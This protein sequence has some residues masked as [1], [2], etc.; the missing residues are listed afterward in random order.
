MANTLADWEVIFREELQRVDAVERQK[1]GALLSVIPNHIE[2]DNFLVTVKSEWQTWCSDLGR[3]PN[4]LVVLYAGLAFYE[5]DENRLWPQFGRAVGSESLQGNRNQQH[6]INAAF[7]KASQ[8]LG[9]RILQGD[10]RTYFIGSAVYHIGI[11]LSLWEGFLEIC[12][13][14]LWRDDWKTLSDEEW[15]E[16]VGK[17]VGGRQRLKRFLIDNREVTS[18]FIKEMLDAREILMGNENLTINSLKQACLLRPEYFDEVPETAEFLR[19]KAPDSLFEDRARLV[20][21]EQRSCIS[22]YLPG[23]SRDKLP[24]T[25]S[26]GTCIEKASAGPSKMDLNSAAFEASL[27]LKLECGK[28]SEVQKLIGLKPWGLFDLERGRFINPKREQL[29]LGRYVLISSEKFD[30]I[31]RKGFDEEEYA[32]NEPYDLKDN[33]TCFVTRLWPID[34]HATLSLTQGERTWKLDFRPSTRIE[35][36]FFTGEGKDAANF[37]R[38]ESLIKIERLPLLC[39]AIP[40]GYFKNTEST[41]RSKFQVF[42]D[43]RPTYGRWKRRHADDDREFY[44]WHWAETPVRENEIKPRTLRSF[45]ELNPEEF[46]ARDLK[47]KRTISIKAPELGVR[48]EY[49][50]EILKCRFDIDRCWKNLPGAFLLWFLLDQSTQGMKWSDL[51]LAKEIIAPNLV[52]SYPLLRKYAKYGL[53]KQQGQIWEI[54]ESRAVLEDSATG[55]CSMQF[56][57]SPS[58]LCG[59]FGYMN[60]PFPKFQLPV[61]EIINKRGEMPFLLM[62]WRQDQKDKVVKYLKE[63]DVRIISNL[64]R[65]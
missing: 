13:W 16:S 6:E 56:C 51:M 35:A 34:K 28:Q 19:P 26:V 21:D 65:Y 27:V 49:Q 46:K 60:N 50:I 11:P 54:A 3:Y 15:A 1:A 7:F 29:P 37:S 53:I 12:E 47:G 23:V 25:W 22:L 14:A 64:W 59:L 18:A 42:V 45:K 52:I 2:W 48:F 17:R 63:H 10:N 41:L 61:I 8:S 38:F 43:E 32:I 58:L 5:Y 9:L 4:C 36:R 20:W 33:T 40:L 62:K 24:A 55:E 30:N 31:L 57:G 44:F 39:V